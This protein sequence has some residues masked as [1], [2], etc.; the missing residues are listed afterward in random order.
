MPLF[1]NINRRRAWLLFTLLWLA[2]GVAWYWT[3]VSHSLIAARTQ[4]IKND[5]EARERQFLLCLEKNKLS[6]SALKA[7]HGAVCL[8]QGNEQCRNNFWWCSPEYWQ[9]QCIKE[10]S[11][12]CASWANVV[13]GDG[14]P[15]LYDGW[16]YNADE[17][18]KFSLFYWESGFSEPLREA[19]LFLLFPPA[20]FAFAPAVFRR[21]RLWLTSQ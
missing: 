9:E 14:S 20:V 6:Y 2:A 7:E 21:L 3:A 5:E 1:P 16:S 13:G 12:P 17:R 4:K 19:L 11:G 10:R 15:R 8:S 18:A